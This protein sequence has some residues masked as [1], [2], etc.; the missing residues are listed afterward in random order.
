[1]LGITLYYA[2]SINKRGVTSIENWPVQILCEGTEY[3]CAL[4]LF[5][6]SALYKSFTYLAYLSL[7]K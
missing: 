3:S 5:E 7:I 2:W 6:T 4:I 1:M